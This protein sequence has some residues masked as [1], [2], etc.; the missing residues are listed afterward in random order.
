M[1]Y[2]RF[3][4]NRDYLA[5][6]TEEGLEQ[7]I[8]EVPDRIPQAEMAAEMK[9]LEYLDQYYEIEKALAV[10]KNI[11]EYNALISYPSGVFFKRDDIIYQTLTAIN[12]LKKPSVE[13]YW[14][15]ME[16]YSGITALDEV[17][18]YSQLK[19]Y[20]VGCITKYGTEYYRCV[21]PNGFDFNDIRIPS[22]D[23]WVEVDTG[24]WGAN[25][26]YQLYD[27]VSYNDAYYTLISLDNL[28]LTVDPHTSD[29]W[30]MI[31]NYTTGI[32][33]EYGEN[34][35]D[36]VVFSD[37]VFKAIINPNADAI[38]VGVNIVEKE[39]R[40][41]NVIT[42]MTR[43]SL[44]YLHQL[45]SPTNISDTRR[46]MYEDSLTW[47]LHASKFKL[48]PQIPRKIDRDS[49]DPKS[50]FAMASF[51]RQYNPNEDN[52]YI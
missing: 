16:D 2:R 39:P 52:W 29:N 26:N 36:Y 43:I 20:N 23:A 34:S 30:G 18:K 11:R 9:M 17:E 50:D 40:N 25:Y 32:N 10:G 3:L 41:L 24:A 48:N 1:D 49:G 19:T 8:R 44:Y 28:D 22:V 46:L 6:I 37:K 27:V 15:M 45:I 5:I 31:G 42:H 4:T 51:E 35:H 14:I 21:K 38:E 47:L 12:G 13:P 33:Y 7:L